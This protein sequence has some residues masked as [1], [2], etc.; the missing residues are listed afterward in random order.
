MSV[1]SKELTGQEAARLMA[2][3][4]NPMGD[5]EYQAFAEEMAHRTHRTLQQ[6]FMRLMW[7]VMRE[8]AKAKSHDLRNEGTV[9]LCREVTAKYEDWPPLPTV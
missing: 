1:D 2:D 6:S 4:V 7:K 3:F 8:F 5:L 9:K